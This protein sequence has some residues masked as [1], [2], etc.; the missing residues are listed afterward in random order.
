MADTSGF[1][2]V[3]VKPAYLNGYATRSVEP[4]ILSGGM[5]ARMAI[6]YGYR[7]SSGIYRPEGDH[8]V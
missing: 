3:Q 4:V 6:F 1:F 5:T 8:A 7:V 2:A